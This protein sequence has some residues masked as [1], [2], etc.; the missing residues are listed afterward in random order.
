MTWREEIRET[1]AQARAI[2]LQ[3]RDRLYAAIQKHAR[4]NPEMNKTDIGRA[5]GCSSTVVTRALGMV[6]RS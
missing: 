2:R 6:E 4:N 5:C 3:R 1:N